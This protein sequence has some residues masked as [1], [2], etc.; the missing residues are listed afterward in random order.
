MIQILK[1]AARA[2]AAAIVLTALAAA[3]LFGLSC[4]FRL[5]Y[6]V[7]CKVYGAYPVYRDEDYEEQFE[8]PYIQCKAGRHRIIGVDFEELPQSGLTESGEADDEDFGYDTDDTGFSYDD[9]EGGYYERKAL[10]VS[11]FTENTDFVGLKK[12]IV[13]TTATVSYEDGTKEQVELGKIVLYPGEDADEKDLKYKGQCDSKDTREVSYMADRELTIKQVQ[14]IP[15]GQ[16]GK[17]R[18]NDRE[19]EE[20][21]GQTL[22][23]D[24]SL[25][26]SLRG[27]TPFELWQSMIK[28]TYQTDGEEEAT[29]LITEFDQDFG[30][31]G[32]PTF[33]QNLTFLR[34]RGVI[35]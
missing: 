21:V 35:Q 9:K 5:G 27:E 8:I 19:P 20:L 15:D 2:A 25:T 4:Y 34:D 22:R 11:L 33:M 31:G 14:C 29:Q 13:L 3:I 12:P 30:M 26:I 24:Y 16:T 10:Q 1:P 23:K 32:T 28:I 18:I 6:P 7:L 17:V